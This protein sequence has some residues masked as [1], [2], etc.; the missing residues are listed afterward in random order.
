MKS[1]LT[2]G[3]F[4]GLFCTVT[5]VAWVIAGVPVLPGG[6]QSAATPAPILTRG[7]TKTLSEFIEMERFNPDKTWAPVVDE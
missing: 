3:I 7:S 4:I 6:Q 2:D 1:D 5:A